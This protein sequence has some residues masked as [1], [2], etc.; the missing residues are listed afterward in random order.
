MRKSNCEHPTF[1]K[2]ILVK[3]H[4]TGC[5]SKFSRIKSVKEPYVCTYFFEI[6]DPYF[7]VHSVDEF[8]EKALVSLEAH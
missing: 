7:C 6:E 5:C 8:W 4:A 3:V 2:A 1:L